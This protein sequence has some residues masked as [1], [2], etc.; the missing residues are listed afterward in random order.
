MVDTARNA[1]RWQQTQ[2][3]K[4]VLLPSDRRQ[5]RPVSVGLLGTDPLDTRTPAVFPSDHFGLVTTFAWQVT[6]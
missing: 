2:E 6:E 3:E 4:R 5:W 1:M